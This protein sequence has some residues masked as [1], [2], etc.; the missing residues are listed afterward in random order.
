MDNQRIYCK[1]CKH[2]YIT[3]NNKFPNGC[4]LYGIKSNQLPSILVYRS[5]GKKCEY[6]TG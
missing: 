5:T 6:F 4:K 1:K 3:W 2:Y